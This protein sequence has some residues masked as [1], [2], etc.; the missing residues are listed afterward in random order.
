MGKKKKKK[1]INWKEL[2]IQAVIDFIVGLALILID[3]CI[4]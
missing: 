2:A 1:P 3:K 4:G